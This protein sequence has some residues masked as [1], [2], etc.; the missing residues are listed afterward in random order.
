VEREFN[1]ADAPK[2]YNEVIKDLRKYVFPGKPAAVFEVCRSHAALK[3]KND[4]L[5]VV[6]QQV[7]RLGRKR[8]SFL[9]V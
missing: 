5:C 7:R 8:G 6:L 3:Q 4:L 1:Y 2:P 9:F